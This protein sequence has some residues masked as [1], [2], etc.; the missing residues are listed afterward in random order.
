MSNE[1]LKAAD[2]A[3]RLLKGFAGIQQV[4]DAFEKAGSAI[5]AQEE[6]EKAI[7]KLQ[8]EAAELITAVGQAKL[9]VKSAKQDAKDIV[10]KAQEAA[11]GILLDANNKAQLVKSEADNFY[12]TTKTGCEAMVNQAMA[13]VDEAV[14][15]RDAMAA[16]VKDLEARADK[17]RAYLAKLQ[18]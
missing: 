17:A 3:K 7:P 12:S 4:A 5:Q 8:A 14:A 16:E 1:F 11:E 13:K 9:D 6:A 10:A 18:G 15:Q 2:D